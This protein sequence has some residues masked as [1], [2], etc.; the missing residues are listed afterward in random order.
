MWHDNNTGRI[1]QFYEKD[2][3]V[4]L[5]LVISVHVYDIFMTLKPETLE[6]LK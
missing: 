6:K 1:V 5:E 4:K 2:V 3:E